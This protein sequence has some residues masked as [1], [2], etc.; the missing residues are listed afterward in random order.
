MFR[1]MNSFVLE[2]SVTYKA[3]LWLRNSTPASNDYKTFTNLLL[4]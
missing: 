4:L 2:A 1:K 3:R